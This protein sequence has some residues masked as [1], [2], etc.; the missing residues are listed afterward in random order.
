M[1][2]LNFENEKTDENSSVIINPTFQ[3]KIKD[4]FLSSNVRG[5]EWP[6]GHPDEADFHFCG[7]ERFDEKPYCI[8]HCAIAYI[9][10]EKDEVKKINKPLKYGVN[11]LS[12]IHI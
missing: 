11:L 1:P 3:P 8:E 7:K 5:C 6:K 9:V 10:P 4:V 2:K 12:L